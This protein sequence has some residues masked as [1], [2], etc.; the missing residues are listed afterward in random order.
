MEGQSHKKIGPY[1]VSSMLLGKG[2]FSQVY[3]AFDP[4]GRWLAAK[5]IPLQ[6]IRCNF[7]LTQ[8]M[9]FEIWRPNSTSSGVVVTRI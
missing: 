8:P 3:L 4:L 6:N 7:T 2:S 1:R 5:T 9:Q